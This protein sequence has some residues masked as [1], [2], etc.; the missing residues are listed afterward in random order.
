MLQ[1]TGVSQVLNVYDGFIRRYPDL[2]SIVDG[3]AVE[4]SEVLR[5][6]GRVERW[7]TLRKLAETLV[8][9]HGGLVPRELESLDALPGIGQ[10]SARAVLCLAY[11]QA[12][13]M[14]DPNSYRLLSRACGIAADRARPHTD[15]RLIERL[16][17][18]VPPENP[19]SFN[20]A[21]LDVGSTICRTKRPVHEACPL[22]TI[23]RYFRDLR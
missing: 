3:D 15:L 5:P 11:G 14:L 18:L 23:C 13:I 22:R 7:P 4:L 20:L 21:L 10:Y 2:R 17:A 6:L 9:E 19:R 16:D 1:R 12:R 8:S